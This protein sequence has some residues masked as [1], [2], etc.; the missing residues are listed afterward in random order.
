MSVFFEKYV[1]HFV[2]YTVVFIFCTPSV[3]ADERLYRL[4]HIA[5]AGASELA[6]EML[7]HAQPDFSTDLYTWII[8]EQERYAILARGEEWA[9]LLLRLEDLP[10]TIPEQFKYQVVTYQAKAHIELGQTS[11]ARK[12]LR[13]QLWQNDVST[14]SEY[15][16]W[17]QLVIQSYLQDNRQEDARVAML[18]FEQDFS[19]VTESWML[20]RATI[21][22]QTGRYDEAIQVL[23]EQQSWQAK[24]TIL[25]ARLRSDSITGTHLWLEAKKNLTD[26]R[27]SSE[28]ATA[29]RALMV[30]AAEAMSRADHIVALERYF[31]HMGDSSIPLFTLKADQL[32]QAYVAY[33][34][35]IGNQTKLLLGDDAGWLTLAQSVLETKPVKARALFAFLMLHSNDSLITEAAAHG[36]LQT[37]A[38]E[39]VPVKVL[40]NQLF[41]HSDSFLDVYQIPLPIRY[42]LVDFALKQADIGQAIELMSS[43]SLFPEGANRW[44]WQLRQAR[45]LFIGGQYQAGNQIMQTLLSTYTEPNAQYTDKILQILFDLQIL[46]LHEDAIQYFNQLKALDVEPKQHREILFW[47]ADSYKALENYHQ[48]ALFYLRSAMFFVPEAMDLWAQSARFNAADS[49]EKAGLSGDARRIYETLLTVTQESQRRSVLTQKIQRLWLN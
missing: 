33:A 25:L 8:W 24:Y 46:N 12:I 17:R 47:I 7:D 48:A 40:L 16:T 23:S 11:R 44:S 20:L 19:S 1:L 41:N 21:L 9:R 36:F 15:R 14:I 10:L 18:R 32:W 3:I 2:F 31:Q 29:L 30:F 4:K 6:L 28:E 13:S 22:I 5:A 34:G 26:K 49:L 37:F 38:A 35:L 45:V 43:L 39:E 42:Q 27:V